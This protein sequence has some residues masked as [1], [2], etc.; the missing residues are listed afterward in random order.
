VTLQHRHAEL[1][2][3]ID[4]ALAPAA[5]AAVE[6]HVAACAACRE[7]VAELR[8][9]VALLQALPDPV[10]SR[11]LVPRLAAGPAWLAPLRTV[12][13]LASGTAVF[14][15]IASSLVS[16]ITFLASG[17]PTSAQGGGRDVGT[18]FQAGAPSAAQPESTSNRALGPVPAS[19]AKVS[20]DHPSASPAVGAGAAGSPSVEDAAKR[21]DGITAAPVAPDVA[22]QENT[23]RVASA[24]PQRSPLLNPWL[25]LA[26]AILTGVIAIALQR[27]LRGS[28]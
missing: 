10:P 11:R 6:G 22:F 21:G 28:I 15:F 13:T 4:G 20:L 3:Y 14:L 25:W 7:H 17:S 19:S 27:R 9:T 16:N 26:L 12:M 2:A 23:G 5:L 18:A 1:S 24:E 8:G